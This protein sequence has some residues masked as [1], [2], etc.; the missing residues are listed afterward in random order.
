MS[1]AV[2]ITMTDKS[3]QLVFVVRWNQQDSALTFKA[4]TLQRRCVM[5]HVVHDTGDELSTFHGTS[6]RR[7]RSN[8]LEQAL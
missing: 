1:R 5:Y 8:I 6:H 4:T 3:C 7:I 2:T